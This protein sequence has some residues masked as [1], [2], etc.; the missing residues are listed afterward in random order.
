MTSPEYANPYAEQI[1]SHSSLKR[2]ELRASTS[3]A[4]SATDRSAKHK[5]RRLYRLGSVAA[6]AITV[7]AIFAASTSARVDPDAQSMSSPSEPETAIDRPPNRAESIPP[8]SRRVEV[9]VQSTSLAQP[10]DLVDVSATFDPS[11]VPDGPPTV[12]IARRVTVIDF[13]EPDGELD[14][15]VTLEVGADRVEPLAFADRYGDLSLSLAPADDDS[16][17]MERSLPDLSRNVG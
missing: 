14:T 5:R 17:G 4:T 15:R 2:V 9:G 12:R 1:M 13:A 10:G 7:L 6:L 3:G 8:G 16:A 11:I